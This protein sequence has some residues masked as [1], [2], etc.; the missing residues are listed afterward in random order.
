MELTL[1]VI[2]FCTAAFFLAGF[3]D[4]VAGGGGLISVPALL[5]SGVPPHYTLGTGKFS[6]TLGS[7]TALWS[8]ARRH[9]VVTRIAPAGFASA[10]FGAIAGS[11]LA[12]LLD[13]S[14][15]GTILV[16]LLPAGLLLS[17]LSGRILTEE[18]ALPERHLWV[19]VISMG[20]LIGAY[21]GFFGPGT[22]SFFILA[23]HLVLHIGLVRASATAKVFNLASNAGALATF[24]SGGV[25]LYALGIPCAL[26]SIAGNQ[27]GVRLAMRVGARAVRIFLYGTLTVLILTLAC[28]FFL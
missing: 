20:L 13:S 19:K 22:G 25:V 4:A 3:V 27:L 10:F 2:L 18:G 7:L 12:L 26:G 16:V 15:L 14:V 9:M 1:P 11:W 21:D 6:S 8:F 28:R 17:L 24:A 5:L 23:Q